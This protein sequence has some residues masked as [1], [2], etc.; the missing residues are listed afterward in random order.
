MIQCHCDYV[1]HEA[2]P[3]HPF[4]K[5]RHHITVLLCTWGKEKEI[6]T[7]WTLEFSTSPIMARP[8][9]RHRQRKQEQM[10]NT[11]RTASNEQIFMSGGFR[12]GFQ[13]G[14]VVQGLFEERIPQKFLETDTNIQVQEDQRLSDRFNLEESSPIHSSSK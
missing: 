10:K 1:S 13:K 14:K 7:R 3:V 4:P 11:Y 5:S 8:S 9:I 12:R 6:D 2:Y